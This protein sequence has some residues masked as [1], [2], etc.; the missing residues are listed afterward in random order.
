MRLRYLLEEFM[1]EFNSL[2]SFRRH[3]CC[4]RR[5]I[6]VAAV[7]SG[8]KALSRRKHEEVT[9]ICAA[10]AVVSFCLEESV[11]MTKS[12]WKGFNF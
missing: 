8:S 12:E 11:A 1:L 6:G 9:M 4:C 7:L 5:S 3:A 10:P 2:A